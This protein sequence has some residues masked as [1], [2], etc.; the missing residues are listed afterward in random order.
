MISQEGVTCNTK[1]ENRIMNQLNNP[2][3]LMICLFLIGYGQ[4]VS[5]AV[6]ETVPNIEALWRHY[7][8]NEAGK[9]P[10]SNFPYEHC[11]R[12]AAQKYD[13]P[14]SL[15]LAVARGESNF[16]PR[17][18]SD[19]NCHG[20]MQIQW[21]GTA[22]HLGIYRLNALY[23]P[24]TNIRAGAKYL[25]ELLDRYAENLHLA[26]AAY[27]YG[28]N[29]IDRGADAGRIP[30]GAIWYSGYIYHHLQNIMRAAHITAGTNKSDKA[31]AYQ[32]QKR[33]GLITFNQPYRANAYFKHLKKREPSLN[34]D[35]YRIGLGRY[36]VVMLYSDD[37]T[38]ETGRKKLKNLGVIVNAR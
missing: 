24:C 18:K 22:K 37:K 20:L 1:H 30:R 8:V 21:P 38:L 27:N 15:L 29:R 36:Q 14:M 19:R 34:L 5:S 28:P 3:K 23:E 16:N 11:F 10:T 2:T 13:L 6:K 32:R 31:K 7:A 17:A 12:S 35:W 9:L 25:R 33:L 4:P 26:L